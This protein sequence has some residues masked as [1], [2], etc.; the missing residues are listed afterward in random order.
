VGQANRGHSTTDDGARRDVRLGTWAKWLRDR[1][2]RTGVSECDWLENE[3]GRSLAT[4]SADKKW[5][6]EE[7]GRN[8][9]NGGS[10]RILTDVDRNC[11]LNRPFCQFHSGPRKSGQTQYFC[12]FSASFHPSFIPDHPPPCGARSACR[13][14]ILA[15]CGLRRRERIT[16][17]EIGGRSRTLLLGPARH[18]TRARRR[19]RSLI[20]ADG[21]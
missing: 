11:T 8:A 6:E 20:L 21:A 1:L 14:L 12:D 9:G 4:E 18:F 10:V 3:C 5:R 13:I 17:A 7:L 16:R 19:F 15:E 2:E